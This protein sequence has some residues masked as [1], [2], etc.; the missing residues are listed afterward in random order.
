MYLLSMGHVY[1]PI[2]FV[3]LDR[4]VSKKV[5]GG[6]DVCSCKM[7]S[8]CILWT[9]IRVQD[10]KQGERRVKLFLYSQ[11]SGDLRDIDTLMVRVALF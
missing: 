5:R 3:H 6:D 10:K 9:D 8:T 1:K 11:I 7:F 2:I 4:M